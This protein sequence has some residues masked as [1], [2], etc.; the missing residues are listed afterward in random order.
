M[1][2]CKEAALFTDLFLCQIASGAEPDQISPPPAL[3]VFWQGWQQGV[4]VEIN[5]VVVALKG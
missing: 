1:N 3:L 4:Q 2:E 5:Q